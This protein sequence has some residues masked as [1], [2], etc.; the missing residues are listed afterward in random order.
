MLVLHSDVLKDVTIQN[1]VIALM[2]EIPYIGYNEISKFRTSLFFLQELYIIPIQSDVHLLLF[3][4]Q[5]TH[6]MILF[7][8]FIA[9]ISKKW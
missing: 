3:W 5:R 1:Y 4:L 8:H 9:Q 6:R 7:T 2:L